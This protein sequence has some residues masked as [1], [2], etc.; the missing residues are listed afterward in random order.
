VKIATHFSCW[1]QT[2]GFKGHYIYTIYADNTMKLTLKGDAF[3][4]SSFSPEMLPRVGIEY[5]MPEEMEAVKWYGLGPGEN[6]SDSR[7]A[8]LMG[9]Y[10]ASVEEMHTDYV[11]PQENGHREQVRWLSVGD[12]T[13][14]LLVV[15]EKPIG[16]NVHDYTIEALEKATHTDEI[17]KAGL[18]V[19]QLD[20][21]HSGLGSNSCGQEQTYRHKAGINDFTMNLCFRV[22]TNDTIIENSK[23]LT[24][25]N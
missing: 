19:I 22:A 13:N 11:M 21:K 25:F 5:R 10:Q 16:I 12:Q 14:S 24:N 23:K 3:R 8:A 20:A 15:S 18:T 7:E 6:Y 2:W 17:E 4:Y 1:N 9:V